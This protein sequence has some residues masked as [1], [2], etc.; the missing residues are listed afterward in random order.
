[1]IPPV[2]MRLRVNGFGIRLPVVLLWPLLLLL[3]PIVFLLG[4]LT[5]QPLYALEVYYGLLC[6]LRGL[7]VY[8]NQPGSIVELQLR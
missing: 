7:Q 4:L 6:S 8:V 3:A 1:M 5:L 2:F